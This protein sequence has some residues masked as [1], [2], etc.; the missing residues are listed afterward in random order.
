[1]L[2]QVNS[3]VFAKR[4]VCFCVLKNKYLVCNGFGLVFY[5]AYI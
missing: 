1:M 5:L 3:N 4:S 2:L